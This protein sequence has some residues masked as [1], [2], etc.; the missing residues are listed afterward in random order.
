MKKKS[1]NFIDLFSGCG[2]FS[3]GL[4]LAGHKCLLGVDSDKN[5]IETFA[6][7]H[8]HA[9][10]FQNKIELLNRETLFSLLNNQKV[11]MVVG[12]PPCQGFSTVG[13]GVANDQRNK[14]FIHFVKIVSWVKPKVVIFEN[15][16]GLLAEKNSSVLKRIFKQF[17]ALGYS[18]SAKILS[19]E[20]FGAPTHR[21][22]TFI[23]GTINC[24]PEDLYPSRSNKFVTV[25][26]AW[27]VGLTSISGQIFNHDLS[28]TEIVNRTDLE[29]IKHIPEG[30]AIRYKMDEDKFLPKKLKL[31]LNW[32]K[33]PE[34]RLRQKKFHRLDRKK[35]SPTVMT[36][37]RTYYH[38][39]EPR[40]LTIREVAALQS[41]PPS[42]QFRGS[43][44][45]M[46][47]Q[48]GNAV[49]P[50]VA[51]AFGEKISTLSFANNHKSKNKKVDFSMLR[52]TAFRY[53]E[54]LS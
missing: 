54:D 1:L 37:S 30:E 29:R 17:E 5:A 27:K 43:Y 19:A 38:P 33:L 15:V 41:F 24:N 12:G 3:C 6:L 14:L 32:A 25:G 9:K 20:D 13:R 46:Y 22:R 47:R 51:K 7:N 40:F 35:I 8:T 23:I 28:K 34:K 45:S 50:L 4:E 39:V 42:F 26:E 48:I 52:S 53:Q 11:D 44:T 31:G 49:P 21:R 10:V 36:S 2:G 18:M 16:T